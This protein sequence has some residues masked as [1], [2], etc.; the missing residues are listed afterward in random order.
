MDTVEQAIKILSDE[1][2]TFLLKPFKWNN[3][4]M[5]ID[6]TSNELNI[7]NK[8]VYYNL[9]SNYRVIFQS[10]YSRQLLILQKKFLWFWLSY[11]EN[12]DKFLFFTKARSIQYLKD[13]EGLE[14]LISFLVR[15]KFN[16]KHI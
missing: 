1:R 3:R 12:Y 10:E 2:E 5:N 13:Q 8:Y 14:Q 11:H 16:K 7:L 4:F 9:G 6:E 15:E